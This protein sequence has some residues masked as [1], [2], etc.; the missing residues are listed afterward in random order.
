MNRLELAA[1]IGAEFLRRKI[2]VVLSG[3]SCVSIYSAERYVSMDLDFV[4]TRFAKRAVIRDAMAS[5]GFSEENRY[6][7]HPDTKLLVEFP[8]GPLGVGEEPVKQ[9][10]EI[11]T[12]TG[13]VRIIS[14]T[15]CVKDR[16]AWYF[17]DND[18]ECLEQAVLVAAVN[19]VDIGEIA[20]WSAVEGRQEAFNRIR[21]RLDGRARDVG[22]RPRGT[23]INPR[24]E[25][26]GRFRRDNRRLNASSARK[27]KGQ[28]NGQAD[29]H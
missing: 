21:H 11:S 12:D 7:C 18:T 2:N 4:N 17:H 22:A 26:V 13:V 25:K 1:F 10:D 6:Y 24:L 8:P 3:G 16:L 19:V 15:D 28:D 9:I 29:G 14:T 27:G 20:R 23:Q 5:L